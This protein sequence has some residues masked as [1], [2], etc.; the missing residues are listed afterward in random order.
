MDAANVRLLKLGYFR[1]DTASQNYWQEVE[2]IRHGLAGWEKL[3]RKYNVK[4]VYHTHSGTGYMG[5]NCAA[6]MH[7]LKGFDPQCIGAYLDPGHMRVNGEP[8]AFGLAM[9]KDYL[10]MIGLKD[11]RPRMIRNADSNEGAVEWDFVPAGQGGV[12]WSDVFA[13]LAAV[14]F[15]GPCSVHCEFEV[16]RHAPHLFLPL[17]QADVS[18]FRMKR[19]AAAISSGQ[20]G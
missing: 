6:L 4:V 2:R 3:A 11:V 16:P 20:V 1:F 7:L 18:Y 9:V 17:A 14:G 13:S 15:D 10:A 19:D 8:F 12:A 5:T